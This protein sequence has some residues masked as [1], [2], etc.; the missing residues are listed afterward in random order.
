MDENELRQRTKQF[1]PRV[2]KL[3]RSLPRSLEARI[4]ADQLFR[5]ATS[6]AS[7]Y[8]AACRARSKKDFVSKIGIVEEE[9]DESAFWLEFIA[10][11]EMMSQQ[12]VQNLRSEAEQLRRIFTASRMTA[13]FPPRSSNQKSSIKNQK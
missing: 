11:G 5:C 9:A 6:V 2:L 12:R 7:N 13:T 4:V 3:V 10:D 8:R 1:A